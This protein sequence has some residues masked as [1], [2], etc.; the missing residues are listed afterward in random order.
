[1]ASSIQ[2]SDEMVS[3]CFDSLISHYESKKLYKPSFTNDP[4]PLFVTWK[5][6]KH[7]KGDHEL[8]GCI[9][10]FSNIPLVEGL[11]KFALSSAL[12]D[13]RFKPIPQRE[14][15]KLSCAVSLL[16]Q[17]EDAKDCWDWEIGT[18]GIWIEFNTDGQ[19]RNATYLP[20]VMPEQEWTKEEALR[21]LVKKAGYHGKV[22]ETFLKTIKLTRYQSSKKTL[23]YTQYLNYK[24]DNNQ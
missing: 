20:E 12:K 16:V 24:K 21:S 14:L 13:D 22:D 4:F 6:D 23:S 3:Y 1:M 11:N 2:V 15:E 9:G 17:F 18:H 5:I 8:R 7:G 19:K 10:T